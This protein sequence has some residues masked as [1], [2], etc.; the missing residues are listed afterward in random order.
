MCLIKSSMQNKFE[1][2]PI[3][4]FKSICIVAC[5][6]RRKHKHTALYSKLCCYC[7][8]GNKL[9]ESKNSVIASII[10]I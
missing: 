9:L 1:L 2:L 10:T 8:I 5:D 4:Y 6:F 7:G 3:I